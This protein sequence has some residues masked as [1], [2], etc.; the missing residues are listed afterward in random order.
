M[1]TTYAEIAG[2]VEPGAPIPEKRM[3]AVTRLSESGV[4]AGVAFI[5]LLPFIS[6]SREKLDE[7]IRIAKESGAEFCFA[8]AL[9]LYGNRP[10]DCKQTYFRFIEKNFPH[11][12]HEYTKIYS[13]SSQPPKSYQERVEKAAS[14]LCASHRIRYRIL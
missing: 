3:D 11:L 1:S 6:D 12:T 2:A 5:P 14:E 8:D 4:Y 9:T 7:M 10:D 13:R